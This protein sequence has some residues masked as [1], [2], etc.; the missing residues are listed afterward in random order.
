MATA[1]QCCDICPN[2]ID[3]APPPNKYG[4][5]TSEVVVTLGTEHCLH[6]SSIQKKKEEEEAAASAND[7]FAQV[8]EK[9]Y[10]KMVP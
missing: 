2:K 7:R 5:A 1:L 4:M 9:L 10:W 3:I 8:K 6:W